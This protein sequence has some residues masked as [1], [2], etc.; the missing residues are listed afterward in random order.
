M[1]LNDGRVD[2]QGRF[3]TGAMVENDAQAP[4]ERGSLYRFDPPGTAAPEAM[5]DG[6]SISNS[7]CFSP[8]GAHAFFADSTNGRILRYP[9]SGPLGD[10][11]LFARTEP[12]SAPD[13]SDVDADGRL[14]NAEW[15]GS[16]V[17]AYNPDGTVAGRLP[18]P[19]SQVTC[20]AFGGPALDLL[21]VTSA[22]EGLDRSAEPHAGDVL[23]YEGPFQGLPAGRF[24]I[25]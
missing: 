21:F 7:I 4:P 25:A 17:T 22:S 9:A 11:T 8:D 19:V 24:C 23:V 16:R 15:G 14:W 13:G 2:R 6:I 5:R 12:G 1:R 18:L 3:W 10:G 20:V